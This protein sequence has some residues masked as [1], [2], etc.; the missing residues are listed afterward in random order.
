MSEP[1]REPTAQSARRPYRAEKKVRF[2]DIDQAGIVYYPRFLH[3]FHVAV[4]EF[5]GD[6]IGRDYAELLRND[7]QGFPMVHLEIDFHRP[8]R[9]GDVVEVEI[10][11]ENVGSTSL[12]WRN[13]VYRM[14]EPELIAEARQV[15]VNISL[16]DY[17]KR[18]IPDWLRAKLEEYRRECAESA[19]R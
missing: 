17:A 5:F 19:G 9:Y 16:D 14:D 15:S 7:R 1:A 2:G 4:E 3:Y 18:P 13:K 10:G 12:I 11:I 8:L 6:V